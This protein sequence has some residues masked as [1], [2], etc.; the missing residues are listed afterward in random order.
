[1]LHQMSK[2]SAPAD[3]WLAC[4]R[5]INDGQP[6][7]DQSAG[8]DSSLQRNPAAYYGFYGIHQLPTCI[9]YLCI[10]FAV[11]EGGNPSYGRPNVYHAGRISP[12]IFTVSELLPRTL[13]ELTF[14]FHNN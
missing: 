2:Y 6:K 8:F 13:V 1:M 11:Y 5:Y 7:P 14:A 12:G 4:L 3:G 9:Q 10:D